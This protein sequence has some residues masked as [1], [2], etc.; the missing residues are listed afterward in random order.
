MDAFC[1]EQGDQY[2]PEY[3]LGEADYNSM[4][5]FCHEQGDQYDPEYDLGEADSSLNRMRIVILGPVQLAPKH[6]DCSRCEWHGDDK[7]CVQKYVTMHQMKKHYNDCL[8]SKTIDLKAQTLATIGQMQSDFRAAMKV[9][10]EQ[11]VLVRSQHNAFMARLPKESRAGKER[12]LQQKQKDL[13]EKLSNRPVQK[14]GFKKRIVKDTPVEVVKARRA[15]RRK[16]SRD[17]KKEVERAANFKAVEPSETAVETAQVETRNTEAQVEAVAQVEKI[18]TAE[19][20]DPSAVETAQVETTAQVEKID[21][22]EQVDPSVVEAVAQVEKIYTAEQVDP[23]AVETVQVE[24]TAQVEKIDTAE[25]VDPSVVETTA[26]VE[27]R[28]EEVWQEVKKMPA[29]KGVALPNPAHKLACTQMCRSVGTN[30]HCR[31]GINCRFAHDTSE[32][33]FLECSFGFGCRNVDRQSSGVYKNKGGKTCNH[34]H[35]GET[36]AS[37]CNRAGI[38]TDKSISMPTAPST[39]S[40]TIKTYQS[41]DQDKTKTVCRSVG[42]DE[43]CRHGSNCRF[44]HEEIVIRVPKELALQAMEIAMKSGKTNIRIEIV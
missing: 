1:H 24:T 4:D 30:E 5:A 7:P 12:R 16:E 40:K 11:A 13:L 43:P 41:S 39:S 27:M 35:P 23:S 2:D 3:D 19:Q 18:D 17:K 10:D 44:S 28:V 6:C 34:M 22:A 9:K 14:A 25:Q 15:L 26:Q 38:K 20:V 8:V 32:L 42:T 33:V 21:T 29:K 37:V 31:H 36:K